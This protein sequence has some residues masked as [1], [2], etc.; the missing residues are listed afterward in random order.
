MNIGIILPRGS[1]DR[2]MGRLRAWKKGALPMQATQN[3]PERLEHV[4]HG[5]CA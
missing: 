2:I 3:N 1:L 5:R 4:G